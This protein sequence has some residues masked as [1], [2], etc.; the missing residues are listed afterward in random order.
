MVCE[1]PYTARPDF[2]SGR[3]AWFILSGAEGYG[4]VRGAPW[5]YS[6]RPSTRCV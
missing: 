1:P 4:G 3:P 6:S 5:D 2:L